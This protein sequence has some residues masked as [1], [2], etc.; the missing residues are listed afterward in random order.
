[1]LALAIMAPLFIYLC[2]HAPLLWSSTT[3]CKCTYYKTSVLIQGMT[4]PTSNLIVSAAAC[5][6]QWN[7][8]YK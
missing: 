2:E 5:P 3:C 6:L 4:W 7:L 8:I 1:V